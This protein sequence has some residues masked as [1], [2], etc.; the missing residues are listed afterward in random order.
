M[1]QS[2]PQ[3]VVCLGLPL[4]PFSECSL[5]FGSGWLSFVWPSRADIDLEE[6]LLVVIVVGERVME[7]RRSIRGLGLEGGDAWRML[8]SSSS[9]DGDSGSDAEWTPLKDDDYVHLGITIVYQFFVVCVVAHL[10]RC[11]KWPPF[12]PR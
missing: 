4:R 2:V 10:W 9:T 5:L 6:H 12:I 3:G 1:F 7:T 11:R 8:Q